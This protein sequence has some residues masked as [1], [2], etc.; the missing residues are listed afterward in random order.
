[1]IVEETSSVT[2]ES[3]LRYGKPFFEATLVSAEYRT[4]IRTNSEGFRDIEHEL[5]KPEDVFRILVL[6]DSF[7]FGLGVEA[8]Q[9]YPLMLQR[10]LNEKNT[11]KKLRYEIFNMGLVGIGTLEELEIAG[12]AIRYRPD[13]VLLGLLVEDRWNSSGNGNDLYDN[14]RTAHKSEKSV[15]KSQSPRS[16]SRRN[17]FIARLNSLHYFLVEN[18]HLYFLIMEK[19][20]DILRRFLVRFREGQNRDELATAWGITK[21][22]LKKI[23]ALSQEA[24]AQFVVIRIPFLYDVYNRGEDRASKILA[25]FGRRNNIYICD[26]ATA[27]KNNKDKDLYYPADGHWKA[28]AHTL[29]AREI[30]DYLLNKNLIDGIL[31]E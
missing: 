5:E 30:F 20:G 16:P 29:A 27:L 17:E 14:F 26:L 28:Q 8:D 4:A 9:S 3:K 15:E 22:A 25:D 11:D 21:D 31:G 10:L 1:M 23:D 12:Y 6:G 13:I 2:G 19:E 24:G 18:S 7:T